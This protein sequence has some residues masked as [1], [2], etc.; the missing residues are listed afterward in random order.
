MTATMRR[1]VLWAGLAG[2]I[3][4]G[5]VFAFR[6]Q[7]VSVDTTTVARGELLVTV[8]EEGKTRVHDI[9][10]LSAPVTGRMRRIDADVGDPVVARQTVV[11]EIEPIAPAF[12]DPR[13]EAQAKADVNAAESASALARAEVDQ[14]QADLD[15]AQRDYDRS[16]ELI[17]EGTISQ[18][19]L[20]EAERAYRTR[21]AALTTALAALD[22]RKF[23][24]QRARAQLVSPAETPDGSGQCACVS[25]RAPVDGR[26]LQV[27]QQSE[28][29]VPAGTPLVEIGNPEDLEIVVDLLTTD[30]VKVQPGQRVIIADWGGSESLEGRVRL[31]EPFGFTKISALGIEEQRV[32]V[33]VD[34]TSPRAQWARLAHGYQV[35]AR[36][37]LA[38]EK[39]ALKL[40]LTALFR[41][42]E[43]WAV[44]VD[45]DGRARLRHVT[46]SRRTGT[47]AQILTGLA[48]GERVVL[49]PSDRV[50]DGVRIMA[51]RLP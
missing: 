46:L 1:I 47:E 10:V 40:P 45:D 8:D 25:L 39:S 44:F 36:I 26:I 12:L 37:V 29:V 6:P 9:Y 21:R 30:A 19:E 51:R 27:L 48:E 41:D 3:A 16:R 17:K 34:I 14:A 38:D 15:F 32:N 22:M 50:A 4:I 42:G 18:R 20:D 11:A 2:L 49:H 31:V 33:I 43:D 7:A 28:N 13:G 24:L 35:E 23:E 5:L